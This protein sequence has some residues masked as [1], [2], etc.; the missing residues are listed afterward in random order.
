MTL[1]LVRAVLVS[2][3]LL[4]VL[5]VVLAARRTRLARSHRDLRAR[6]RDALRTI[7]DVTRMVDEWAG[8]DNALAGP[9]I[10]RIGARVA[11]WRTRTIP[12]EYG[13]R[14]G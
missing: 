1:D 6:H 13:K 14:V 5:A 4:T 2:F 7:A 8:D 12:R 9:V 10:H 11:S 3:G